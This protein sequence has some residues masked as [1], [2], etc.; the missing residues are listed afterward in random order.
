MKYP[1]PAD[2]AE[3]KAR[4]Y[5]AAV[6]AEA[7]EQSKRWALSREICEQIREAFAGV[8]LGSGVG[9]QEGLALDGYADEITCASYR[10]LDETE[11]WQRIP[12]EKLNGCHSSLS[13]FDPE[14]MRFHLPAF[15]IADLHGD[16]R[17]EM[18]FCL[19]RAN[20]HGIDQFALLSDAQR[21][22]VRAYLLFI[23]DEPEHGSFRA[24]VRRALD[25]YWVEVR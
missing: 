17:F 18:S 15:L 12:I 2:I 5:D 4:G 13:F 10:D 9:L 23:V 24:H 20:D 14:G 19:T 22:A 7:E 11:D 25:E 8:K 3:M 6:V 21:R 1:S 16:Y